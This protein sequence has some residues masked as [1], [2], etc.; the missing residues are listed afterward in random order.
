[1]QELPWEDGLLERKVESDLRDL[2]KTLV[3]FSNS[4]RPGHTAIIL[5]G[6]KDDGTVQGVT[7]P[8]N[9]QERVREEC[10]KIY[11][12]IIWRTQVYEKD[13]KH[14]VRVE[15]EYSGNTPHFGGPA[16]VRRGSVTVKA[17]DEVFQQLIELRLD[18]VRELSKW[19]GMSVTVE[20]DGSNM[21]RDQLGRLYSSRW[22]EFEVAAR[23]LQVNGFW[24]TLETNEGR[25]LSEP[26]DKLRLTF[27]NQKKQLK[28][29]VTP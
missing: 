18:K 11:P 1:M 17:S 12:D 6:E 9:I 20:G 29:L 2:L 16:W 3:A 19:V 10:E 4:V 14:C 26:L 22:Q 7:N 8:D 13:G 5:I 27:D 21:P 24:I 15:I 28:I 23:L 25:H